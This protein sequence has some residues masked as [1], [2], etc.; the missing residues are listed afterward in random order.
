MVNLITDWWSIAPL[1]GKSLLLAFVCAVVAV[2][3][4][5]V[6]D[7][8]NTPIDPDDELTE[9]EKAQRKRLEYA[10]DCARR[11]SK[12]VNDMW[13]EEFVPPPSINEINRE[14]ME[15]RKKQN[16]LPDMQATKL[17]GL[18]AALTTGRTSQKE[19]LEDLAHRKGKHIIY[20][21]FT[22]GCA[23]Y[24]IFHLPEGLAM[25]LKGLEDER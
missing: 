21:V 13:T 7:A 19:D 11:A 5:M 6:N 25:Y 14:I 23:E 4:M 3:L 16:A 15:D 17:T 24:R 9:E 18:S 8:R 12:M 2:T 1:W 10:L 20:Q 22:I